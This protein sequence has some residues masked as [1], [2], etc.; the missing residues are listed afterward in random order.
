MKTLIIGGTGFLGSEITRVLVGRGD[1]VMLMARG[2]KPNAF[3]QLQFVACDCS[4]PAAF[5]SAVG[6]RTFDLVVDCA[7]Y[8]R[9][10][11]VAVAPTLTGRVGHFVFIS[12]D[13]TYSPQIVEFP[14]RED[15]AKETERPYGVGKL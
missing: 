11:M 1:Q 3:P 13:F 15:A 7:G 14:I 5:A 4:D 2:N 12:T 8:R 10:D 9:A 6:G